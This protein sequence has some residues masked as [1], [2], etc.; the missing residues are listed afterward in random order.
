MM[1]IAQQVAD[2]LKDCSTFTIYGGYALTPTG[3]VSFPTG[4]QELETRNRQGQV[5]HA[6]YIYADGS[7]LTYKR[8]PDN[9]FTLA[10]R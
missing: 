7:R 6:R 4:V 2:L 9:G 10:T 3:Q 5:E 8:E 1:T